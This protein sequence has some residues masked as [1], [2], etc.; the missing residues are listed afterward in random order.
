MPGVPH[1]GLR[2]RPH[3]P[4]AGSRNVR[5]RYPDLGDICLCGQWLPLLTDL[6]YA[7]SSWWLASE[8]GAGEQPSRPSW[9]YWSWRRP[10]RTAV[11]RSSGSANARF[12]VVVRRRTDQMHSTG[13]RSTAAGK[14]SL[15]CLP[16]GCSRARCLFFGWSAG[17]C[18]AEFRCA[19]QL[20][21]LPV[22]PAKSSTDV[23]RCEASLACGPLTRKRPWVW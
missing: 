11:I 20:K 9:R 6:G 10:R 4:G 23:C 17:A 8:A 7:V 2:G 18:G 19:G 5:A 22:A 14:S 16:I 12:T 3:G 13:S 15:S 21:D 1:R